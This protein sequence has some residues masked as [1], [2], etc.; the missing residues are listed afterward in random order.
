MQLA[1]LLCGLVSSTAPASAR[2]G[3]HVAVDKFCTAAQIGGLRWDG[4]THLSQA[5]APLIVDGAGAVAP[6]DAAAWAQWSAALV[7]AAHGNGSKIV[8]PL[9]IISKPVAATLF[10]SP[11]NA[12]LLATAAGAAAAL[13]VGAGYD[14]VQLDIE[15]LQQPSA[16]GFEA[17]LVAMRRALVTAAAAAAVPTLSLS[18][19]LY[20]PK[21]VQSDFGTYN[22]TRMTMAGGLCDFV[23]LMGYDMGWAA[24]APGSG[25][26]EA[27]PNAPLDGLALGLAH[28]AAVG[29]PPGAMV[30]GLPMYGK[31]FT[32]DGAAPAAQGN[33]STAEK[34]MKNKKVDDL[35][36]AA[37]AAAP[38][39]CTA[40][41]DGATASAVL[42]CAQG[43]AVPGEGP[44]AG[45]R[46]QAWYETRATIAAKVGL[47]DTQ[48]LGGIGF[49]T[50]CGV[51][52][53]TTAEG[54]GTW[55]D[56]AAYVAGGAR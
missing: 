18:S 16:A 7:G 4:I 56:V 11:V 54:R 5:M 22:L 53:A 32:C 14:G 52:P 55:D 40:G 36:A 28:A 29:A 25:A 44:A 3:S 21:L 34:N 19:T 38:G 39:A 45:A 31:V 27:V 9:H 49:W 50:A 33:C 43:I 46:Q 10:A 20:M 37:S 6:A 48:N 13:A 15:G 47:A 41:V 51:D 1:V 42:D 2:R 8:L 12:S 35:I 17:F 30:L 26:R 23:F 24:A